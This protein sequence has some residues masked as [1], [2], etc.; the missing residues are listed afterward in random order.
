MKPAMLE[1]NG[2]F[3]FPASFEFGSRFSPRS[4]AF[5]ARRL[6]ESKFPERGDD[7]Q[8]ENIMM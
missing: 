4:P 7:E 3:E 5:S 2:H 6:R 8:G 1:L